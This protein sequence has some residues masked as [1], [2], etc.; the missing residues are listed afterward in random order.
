MIAELVRRIEQPVLVLCMNKELVEQDRDKLV[1]QGVSATMYCASTG[2]KIIS[3]V[4]VATIQ[5]IYK[6]PEFCERFGVVIIDECFFAGTKVNGKN[7]EDYKVG[8]IVPSYN[9]RTNKIEY[10][11]VVRT[12]KKKSPDD[13]I[14]I[15]ASGR[16]II[17]T[18]NHQHYTDKGWKRADEIKEGDILYANEVDGEA[19]LQLLQEN[20]TAR[21]DNQKSTKATVQK[22]ENLLLNRMRAKILWNKSFGKIERPESQKQNA[23]SDSENEADTKRTWLY[24]NMGNASGTKRRKW[25]L[26]RTSNDASQETG[27]RLDDGAS[28]T[29]DET[30]GGRLSNMLQGGLGEPVPNASNRT[31]WPK[32]QQQGREG[33]R[34]EEDG[35]LKPIRVDC[36]EVLERADYKKLGLSDGGNYV[37]C[38]SVEDNHNFFLDNGVLTHNCDALPADNPNSMYMKFFSKLKVKVVGWTGTPFRIVQ[39]YGKVGNDVVYQSQI[40]ALNRIPM[41]REGF[42]WGK[43]VHG[44]SYKEL[45]EHT[46]RYV[47]PI[48]YYVEATD[49]SMLKVNSTGANFTD[50]SLKEYGDTNREKIAKTTLGAIKTFKPKRCL[51]AVPNIEDAEAVVEMIKDT[52]PAAVLHSKMTKKER[53]DI[54]KRYKSGEIKVVVQVMILNVGFDLPALDLVIFARP[55]LSLRIWAQF[56]ARGIRLDPDDDMKVCRAV[57]MAGMIEKFGRIEDVRVEKEKGGFRTEIHGT[58]GKISD[59]VIAEV[60]MT[61]INR[62]K[63][64]PKLYN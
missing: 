43:I 24:S 45:L 42:F 56:I 5:S 31:R 59:K 47:A 15:K 41:G 17:S 8:D 60:N 39:R 57:D 3:D 11:K 58:Y 55:S 49:R 40:R 18:R 30:E 48:Q 61:Q 44:I 63:V 12:T 16:T 64:R 32:P 23:R 52:V 21:G 27:E 14:C 35:T 19:E 53:A 50:E 36:V 2:E 22:R 4:T 1:D 62:Q 51:V 25:P 10:K 20:D 34:Q 13:M 9:T 54:I 7:I 26:F 6:I 46:P 33:K 28:N 37:Y 38:I 29:N